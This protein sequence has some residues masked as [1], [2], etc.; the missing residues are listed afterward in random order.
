[1]FT[2]ATRA[3]GISN[4]SRWSLLPAAL[5]HKCGSGGFML[6]QIDRPLFEPPTQKWA[7]WSAPALVL[8]AK[9]YGR[10]VW[11]AGLSRVLQCATIASCFLFLIS[12]FSLLFSSLLLHCWYRYDRPWILPLISCPAVLLNFGATSVRTELSVQCFER[13]SHSI[14]PKILFGRP[15]WC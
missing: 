10:Q 2:A 7:V 8:T 3:A 4:V 1:L 9:R 15:P 11:H 5:D 14:P 12:S 6:V 13:A